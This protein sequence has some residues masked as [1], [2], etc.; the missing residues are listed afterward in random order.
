MYWT[1]TGSVNKIERASMDGTSRIAL[2]FT[3][4]NNPYGLTLDIDTQT[5]YW[6]DYSRNVLEM[7]NADG[8]NRVILTRSMIYDPYFIT[9][10]DGSLYWGDW[11][12]YRLLTT[13][14]DNP[15]NVQYFGPSLYNY[16][17]GIQVISS[18]KQR[19]GQCY[20]LDTSRVEPI[21]YFI[22]MH[23]TESLWREQWKL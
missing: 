3:D 5:L 21:L 16:V 15:N 10:Y 18:D 19:Q 22:S 8:T 12:Y 23:S 1:D 6:T 11:G 20:T 17:Y 9:Y 2:H 13:R 7:S 14:V 4:L